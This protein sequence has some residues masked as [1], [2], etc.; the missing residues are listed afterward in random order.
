MPT[1]NQ[2]V[3]MNRQDLTLDVSASK[4]LTVGDHYQAAIRTIGTS[5]ETIVLD[6][7]IID[8]GL[9]YIRNDDASNFVD[10]GFSTG[11]YPNR[12]YPSEQAVIPLALTQTTVY[13][14]ADTAACIIEY[15][16]NERRGVT[17]S[18]SPSASVS[19]SPS[20][21]VSGSPSASPSGSVSA[22]PSSSVSASPSPTPSASVSA[23]PSASPSGSV[24]ASPS[25]SV[26]SS[27]SASPSG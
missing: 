21:S 7:D 4:S 1:L 11:V 20:A 3:T 19:S 10:I 23:S 14:K 15:F 8:P 26:S 18:S 27:P 5:E 24:S 25:A 13:L 9:L 22:S 17:P 12:I 6:A 16:V 2:Y